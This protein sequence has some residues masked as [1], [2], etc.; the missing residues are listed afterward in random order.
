MRRKKISVDFGDASNSQQLHQHIT[1]IPFMKMKLIPIQHATTTTAAPAA[2]AVSPK[3][4]GR[5]KVN[6]KNRWKL[7]SKKTTTKKKKKSKNPW[8]KLYK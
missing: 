1:K 3:S 8:L 7:N 6:R 5:K 2:I 4:K